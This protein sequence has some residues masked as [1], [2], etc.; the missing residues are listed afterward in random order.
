MSGRRG[1]DV[2]RLVEWS[3]AEGAGDDLAEERYIVGGRRSVEASIVE[4]MR[5]GVRVDGG[6]PSSACASRAPDDALEV[7]AAIT[8]LDPELRR[9]V[10]H[11]GRLGSRPDTLADV[12]PGLVPRLDD[13]DRPVLSPGWDRNRNALPRFCYLVEGW[14]AEE[15][16]RV[17]A[18]YD[19]WRRGLVLVRE[20]LKLRPLKQYR[21]EGPAAPERPCEP[22]RLEEV[23][24]RHVIPASAY[25]GDTGRELGPREAP[26]PCADRPAGVFRYEI[27]RPAGRGLGTK[28][29]GSVAL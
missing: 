15:I 23:R 17:R 10:L 21:A 20:I 11:H 29:R 14:T 19:A 16:N 7:W 22:W 27:E 13:R 9:L 2:E 4:L 6:G 3:L 25:P 28:S 26:A 24:P 5:L 12:R 8:S 1:I 18:R